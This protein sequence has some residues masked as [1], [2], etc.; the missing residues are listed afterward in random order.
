M[1]NCN[2][3]IW[4]SDGFGDET[5]GSGWCYAEECYK[6]FDDSCSFWQESL[7]SEPVNLPDLQLIEAVAKLDTQVED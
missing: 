2:S 7:R 4:Y 5:R 3:C 1:P 6:D